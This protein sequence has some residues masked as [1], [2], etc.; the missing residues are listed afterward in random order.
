MEFIQKITSSK[1]R[2]KLIIDKETIMR[3]NDL[4]LLQKTRDSIIKNIKIEKSPFIFF[5]GSTFY[6]TTSGKTKK[7]RYY[8]Q[9]DMY[10]KVAYLRAKKYL[11]RDPEFFDLEKVLNF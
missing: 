11:D 6:V 4:E 3:S 1:N 2:Y 5:E 7:F 10:L 9:N 8:S